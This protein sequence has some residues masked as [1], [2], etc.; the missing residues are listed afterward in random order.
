[1]S[2]RA[3]LASVDLNLLVVLDE[4][5]RSQST[6]VAARRLGRAQSSV[7]HALGR[8]REVFGDPLFVRAGAALRPT[9]FAEE[10]AAPL[11]AR[12]DSLEQLLE[13]ATGVEP[14]RL[15]RTFTISAPDWAEIVIVP[16]LMA[17]LRRE[18][19]GVDV[20][21]RSFRMDVDRAVQAGE[22]DVALGVRFQPLSGLVAQRLLEEPFACI[23][24]RDH[25]RIGESVTLDAYAAAG[26]VL[27]AP[28]ELPGSPLDDELA[29]LGHRRRV[30]LRMPHFSAALFVVAQT[31]LIATL[32][33]SFVR[34]TAP[35]L[36][37][38]VF[39]PPLAV[40]PFS[41]SCLFSATRQ[42]DPAHVWLRRC[43][44]ESC[45][46]LHAGAPRPLPDQAI[47]AV[48]R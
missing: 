48:D 17:R 2:R 32:P 40:P 10:L 7:S 38:R 9:S 21:L 29:R 6:V 18:A 23:A 43:I 19:P 37:L 36:R 46:E 14:S 41:F 39:E 12:L 31:D 28:Y 13:Q 45:R 34:A 30:V 44:A 5:L 42:K 1:M 8:L 11:R 15:E 3:R 26:H 35:L 25:P 24:R 27:V 4:L 22:I 47:D 33:R 20:V 16:P